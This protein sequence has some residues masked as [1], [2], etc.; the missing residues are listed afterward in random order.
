[1]FRCVDCGHIF[2]VGEEKVYTEAHGEKMSCCP[3]CGGDF[4]EVD[5]CDGCYKVKWL[6]ELYSGY[7]ER[8]LR[9]SLNG[10]NISAYIKHSDQAED[11]YIKWYYETECLNPSAELIDL[12]RTGYLKQVALEAMQGKHKAER[13]FWRYLDNTQQIEDY[14]KWLAQRKM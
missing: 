10:A 4:L 7:C 6:D 5:H 14:A 9:D 13:E 8:C 2:D 3:V 11:F 1:M 12:C